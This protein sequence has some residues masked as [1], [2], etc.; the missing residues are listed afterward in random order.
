MTKLFVL[1][2]SVTHN[3]GHLFRRRQIMKQNYS[4]GTGL[5][6]KNMPETVPWVVRGNL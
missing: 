3:H 1:L 2:T 4:N 6:S 5:V